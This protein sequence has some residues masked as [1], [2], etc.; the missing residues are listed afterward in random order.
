MIVI[1]FGA[2]M[3]RKSDCTYGNDIPWVDLGP[4][5]NCNGVSQAQKINVV[6]ANNTGLGISGSTIVSFI[7]LH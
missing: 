3:G 5:W 6:D 7:N 2:K 1:K 4:S